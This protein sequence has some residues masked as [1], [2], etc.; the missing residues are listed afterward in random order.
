MVSDEIKGAAG[1]GYDFEDMGLQK[2]KGKAHDVQVYSVRPS[3][4]S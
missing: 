1:A 2:L 3:A 4:P